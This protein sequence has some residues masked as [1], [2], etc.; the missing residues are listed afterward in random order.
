M[1][2]I[3]TGTT[4]ETADETDSKI[5]GTTRASNLE[6]KTLYQKAISLTYCCVGLQISY[7]LWGILQEKIM[8]RYV[9]YYSYLCII[10]LMVIDVAL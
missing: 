8:T 6:S 9:A 3:L 4:L 10:M 2:L 5:S 1:R 7:L